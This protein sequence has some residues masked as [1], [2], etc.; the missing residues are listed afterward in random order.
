MQPLQGY[1]F[2]LL[3]FD[4]KGEIYFKIMTKVYVL[5]FKNYVKCSMHCYL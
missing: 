4:N 3:Y 2:K 1:K 5:V